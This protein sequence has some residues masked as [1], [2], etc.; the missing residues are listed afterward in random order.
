MGVEQTP[1][2]PCGTQYLTEW[3]KAIDTLPSL[4][5]Q[6]TDMAED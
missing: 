2:L 1:L 3:T 6:H 4:G 5:T